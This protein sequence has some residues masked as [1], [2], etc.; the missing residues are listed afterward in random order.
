MEMFLGFHLSK[1][2]KHWIFPLL[3]GCML[4]F[5][6]LF[7]VNIRA[8]NMMEQEK[9]RET[10]T[11]ID[12]ARQGIDH[13]LFTIQSSA[14]ELLLNNQNMV[15]QSAEDI[16]AFST[17]EAYRYS[18]LMKNIKIAN[19]MIE[20]I[21]LYYPVWD[22]IVGTEGCYNSRNYFLLNS[23]L[24][25]KGY[26][27][28]KSHILESD[29]INFFFSPLGKNEEKLYF[30]Q[31]IPASRERDPQSILIIGVN[32]TE[33][34]RLLDMALPNDDGTSIFVLTEEEQLYLSRM[35]ESAP[36]N[37]ELQ[38]LLTRNPNE[39]EKVDED[40]YVGWE[41]PSA[42][43]AFYY[44]V[45]SNKEVLVAHIK[46]IQHLL[47]M[48]IILCTGI[49]LAISLFL[50]LKQHKSIEKTINSLND[51]VL[52]SIKE[53]ALGDVL[54]QRQ[55]DPEALRNLFQTAGILFD[56]I[57]YSF[58]LADVSFQRDKHQSKEN[59]QEVGQSLE[60][61]YS[62]VDVVPTLIGDTAVFLLNYES[63]DSDLLCRIE[64]L[65]RQQWEK[66]DIRMRQSEVFMSESQ[67]VSI[68]EQ[69]LLFFHKELGLPG[70]T[71]PQE[72]EEVLIFDRWKKALMLREYAE[73]KAMVPEVLASYVLSADD[74]YVRTSRQY[75]VINTVIQ[76]AQGEDTRYHG[77]HMPE[78]MN[79]LK[80]CDSVKELSACLKEI[81]SEFEDLGSQYTMRQKERLSYKIKKII[82]EN[83]NQHFLGLCYISEQVG[84]ST[85]Y[86]SKV[87][88]EEY[89]IGVVEYMNELRIKA[90]KKLMEKEGITIKE[91]AEQVGFTSDIHF[92]RIFKKYENI[93][94][95]VYKRQ[96][97]V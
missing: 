49:G 87:F 72:K 92:I 61:E 22:Y 54:N 8:V 70:E 85:S 65:I 60:R 17:P 55:S 32:D 47:I 44:V 48:G 38:D 91:V 80:G 10:E 74:A 26:A 94:P 76:S 23:G 77:N 68:Y 3:A 18:E 42:H 21:Y 34:M 67:M 75:A 13:Y 9:I 11:I 24:S 88:K 90:A 37:S 56:Y 39:S 78:W 73:A 28:W 20:D 15:L 4:I 14:S 82:E 57:Y 81:L 6:L 89:G 69:T 83:Y 12:T 2:K 25:S 16:S 5:V 19:S 59:L 29:N 93:T 35:K 66:E 41:M 64:E 96:N 43:H 63:T 52:W 84:V 30:R 53:S 31:Q 46:S 62:F 97:K 51:K 27:E 79:A 71:I 45:L 58:I 95:G 40:G 36:S 33:F 86:V 7:A 50:G 1:L